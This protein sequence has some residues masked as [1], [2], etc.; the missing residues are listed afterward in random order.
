MAVIPVPKTPKQAFNKNRPI[1]KLLRSQL[2][3]LEWAVRPASER[4]P[5]QLPKTSVRTEG[6]AAARIGELT[7]RLH[8]EGT[9]SAPPVA[10]P[11]AA[12][13]RAKKKR[14]KSRPAGRRTS[15]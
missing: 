7:R 9:T 14:A 12:V 11:Q 2:E 6:E 13:P 1:S 8:P 4:K 3:H 5:H 15:R 10:E